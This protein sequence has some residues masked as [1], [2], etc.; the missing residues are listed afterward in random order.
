M[1]NSHIDLTSF[2]WNL[3]ATM[4]YAWRNAVSIELGLK[5]EPEVGPIPVSIPGSIQ[6][7]LIDANIVKDWRY[8]LNSRDLEWVEHRH[9]VYTCDLPKEHLQ[10]G[11]YTLHFDGLDYAGWIYLNSSMIGT[12]ENSFVPHTYTITDE[13]I[14][15]NNS[16]SVIFKEPPRWLGQLGYTSRIKDWKPRFYYTWDWTAR[17]VQTAITGS[18]FLINNET[19]SFEITQLHTSYEHS[20]NKGSIDLKGLIK[21]ALNDEGQLYTIQID[22]LDCDGVMM[23][24]LVSESSK[25][26]AISLTLEDIDVKG[27]YPNLHGDQPLYTIRVALVSSDG[28]MYWQ[29]KRHIGFKEVEWRECKGAPR[30]ATPWICSVN[31]KE[32]FLQGINW[33]PISPTFSDVPFV[34]VKKRLDLYKE[35]G[36]NL[37]RVWGG[38]VLETQEFYDECSR[39][40]LMVWQELPLSS[41]GI[42]NWP[43]E[44][45]KVI[46]EIVHIAKTYIIRRSHHVSLLM[47]SGGNELQGSLDGKKSGTGKPI[48]GTH[49]MMKQLNVVFEEYDPQR[50]FIPTSPLGPRFNADQ[51]EYNTEVH[52]SIHGPWNVDGVL[53]ERWTEYWEKDDSLLRAETG[54]PGAMDLAT[55]TSYVPNMSTYPVEQA[56]PVWGRTSWWIESHIYEKEIGHLPTTTQEYVDWSQERQRKALKISVGTT[57]KRFPSIG[58]III[59]MGHDSFPCAANTSIIDVDG[60]PKPAYFAIKEIFTKN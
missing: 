3:Y 56:N 34:E 24:S 1:N 10:K 13:V 58:G 46:E 47:Y 59:W 48:D 25:E 31:G 18:V 60:N 50:R 45:E 54:C 57:K 43:P 33:T 4:P 37:L 41:S 21:G 36:V 8:D 42:D 2:P 52:W 17:V 16:L 30:G 15:E 11:N 40:G 39:L 12:F 51:G 35:M 20:L 5:F 32:V 26:N 22:L 27:W 29:E 55:L 14:E 7:A 44:D 53:D 38:A 28:E 6:Q 9:W 19:P 49:P 23:S